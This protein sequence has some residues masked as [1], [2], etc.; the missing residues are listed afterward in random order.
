MLWVLKLEV[1]RWG[2]SNEYQQHLFLWR[3]KKNINIFGLKKKASYQELWLSLIKAII[4]CNTFFCLF[5]LRFYGPVNPMGSCWARSVYLTTRLLG[6]LS[7]LSCY[8]HIYRK[9]LE[10]PTW[11]NSIDPD[12]M[13]QNAA[14][15]LGLY[16][17]SQIKQ[18]LDTSKGSKIDLIKFLDKNAYK[19]RSEYLEYIQYA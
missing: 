12:Q 9:Y 17:L 8:Y 18:F 14:S 13:L 15:D 11:T 1:P 5:V 6:R 10:R 2:A 3:N 16:C 19:V 4:T 7:P